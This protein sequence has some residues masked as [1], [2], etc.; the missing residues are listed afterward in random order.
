VLTEGVLTE[1]R[2]S[3]RWVRGVPS[4]VST[5]DR[6]W[7]IA[8]LVPAVAVLLVT[9]VYPLGYALWQSLF[10]YNPSIPGAVPVFLGL[11]NYQALLIDP[12]FI[13]S[14][15]VT[16]VFVVVGVT[17]EMGLGMLL[18]LLISRRHPLIVVVRIGL[19]LPFIMAP[20][21]AGIL[22]RTLYN[23]SW[24]P[25]DYF[26]HLIGAPTQLFFGSADQ[27]LGALI[28]V[29]IW[30]QVPPV[31]FI[32][33]AGLVSLPPDVFEAAR[34]DGASRWRTFIHIT[35]P[36]LK[37]VLFVV[38]L[39][40]V[41]D[42]FKTYDIVATATQGG[43]ASATNLVSYNAFET[44]VQYFSLGYASAMS[45]VFLV[46][47]LLVSLGLVWALDSARRSISG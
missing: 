12:I 44:G 26:L 39:L 2:P 3:R 35:L 37:P 25:F 5:P 6:R 29:E 14:A 8:M 21:A 36:L 10:Q 40:R 7:S 17:I 30:Q 46:V 9:N 45:W 33:A 47:V 13:N 38:L 11:G 15:R 27:A 31:A 24:G 1:P 41:M 18:G 22:W 16:I 23:V 34:V 4:L 20:A 28:G 42:A 43:P 19:L 32:I